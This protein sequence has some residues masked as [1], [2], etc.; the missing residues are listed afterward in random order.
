MDIFQKIKELNLPEGKYVIVG[1][2]ILVALGLLE[3]DDDVDICVAPDIFDNFQTQGWRQ[4]EWVGKPVLKHDV[5]DIGVDFGEWS[6]DDLLKDTVTINNIPF[7]SLEKLL[8][9]KWQMKRPKDLRHIA[10]IE[11]YQKAHLGM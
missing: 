6:L 1:G 7:M 4:E 9:W 5:Y 8:T 3:W 2:G 11:E 10:L